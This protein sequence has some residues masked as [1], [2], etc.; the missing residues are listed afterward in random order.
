MVQIKIWV[1]QDKVAPVCYEIIAYG[2]L[3]GFFL[4]NRKNEM[5]VGMY[6]L[7]EFHTSEANS[8]RQNPCGSVSSFREA[9]LW[10]A[11]ELL[12]ERCR[13]IFL[14]SKRDG[15]TYREIA[16]ELN[17]SE[18]TVEHQISKALK[19]LRGKKDDFLA[20]FFY[21]LPFIHGGIL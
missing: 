15:M 5:Q 19:T 21:I 6:Q 8:I 20:D 12:P 4:D 1:L 9:K 7:I 2:I 17:L 3:S 18:K 16:E 13:E 10:T 11:I 14:M